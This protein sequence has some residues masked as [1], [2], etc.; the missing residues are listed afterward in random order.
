M[1]FF[2]LL[3]G[4][5]EWF[6]IDVWINGSN[7]LF[8][9]YHKGGSGVGTFLGETILSVWLSQKSISYK[10]G[11]CIFQPHPGIKQISADQIQCKESLDVMR[12]NVI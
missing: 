1:K 3:G 7:I 5:L 2:T 4:K 12:C 11:P 6:N 9:E 10:L 8:E